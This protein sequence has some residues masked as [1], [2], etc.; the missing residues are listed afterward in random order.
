MQLQFPV[1]GQVP[2]WYFGRFCFRACLTF[3]RVPVQGLGWVPEEV[4]WQLSRLPQG[5]YGAKNT[6]A[7]NVLAFHTSQ[8]LE[9]AFLK[10][11]ISYDF[12]NGC[13]ARRRNSQSTYCACLVATTKFA[14]LWA[15]SM[16][17]KFSKLVDIMTS[18][19]FQ[20]ME[21]RQNSKVA[22]A[23]SMLTHL[24]RPGLK[25]NI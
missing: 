20:V 6:S 4:L 12:E 24:R 8:T 21:Q 5:T 16:P 1:L 18:R 22:W 9:Q 13:I 3:R 19:S 11:I 14:T 7:V 10:S 15:R 17:T 23:S 25:T 2:G